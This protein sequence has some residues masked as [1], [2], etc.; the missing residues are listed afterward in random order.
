MKLIAQD[1]FFPNSVVFQRLYGYSIHWISVRVV[2]LSDRRQFSTL[3]WPD[4]Y[5]IDNETFNLSKYCLLFPFNFSS[6]SL[7]ID[8]T[9]RSKWGTSRQGNHPEH[10][11]ES[12]CIPGDYPICVD[13]LKSIA[14]HIFF[15]IISIRPFSHLKNFPTEITH[16]KG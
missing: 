1:R 10:G 16:T 3:T 2:Y 15:I 8:H 12:C 5:N 11:V 9:L 14:K 6:L 7:P 4:R 13:S